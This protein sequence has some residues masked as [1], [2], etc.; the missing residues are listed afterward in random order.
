MHNTSDHYRR[1][2]KSC[3]SALR[4]WLDKKY[5][6]F[7]RVIV[8]LIENGNV[9]KVCSRHGTD[10]TKRSCIVNGFQMMHEQWKRST[11]GSSMLVGGEEAMMKIR[12][13]KDF[14]TRTQKLDK[15]EEFER[16]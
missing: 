12:E 7:E 1:P 9:D 4:R 11:R 2:F 13:E 10:V 14:D 5:K 6:H 16:V 8:N 3:K 15:S